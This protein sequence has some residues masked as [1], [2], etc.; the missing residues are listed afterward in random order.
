MHDKTRARQP[1]RPCICFHGGEKVPTTVTREEELIGCRESDRLVIPVKAGHAAGGKE[2]THGQARQG[3][4]D[5][6][7]R[8]DIG[9]NKT[10]SHSHQGPQRTERFT[11]VYH[12][13]NRE[14]LRG[15]FER[16]RGDAAAGIDRVTKEQYGQPVLMD[17]ERLCEEP[18]A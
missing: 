7:R 4:I 18:C 15:C 12:L 13:M 1:G 5:R 6:T 2:A 3:D 17:G 16:L 11:R 14:L 8:R 10:A 9:G